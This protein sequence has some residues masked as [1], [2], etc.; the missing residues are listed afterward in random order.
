VGGT[1]RDG[2]QAQRGGQG[3]GRRARATHRR[4]PPHAP[5][6]AR[7]AR[8][9]RGAGRADARRAPTASSG[10]LGWGGPGG[11][12]EH[13]GAG[14]DGGWSE[15]VEP[16]GGAACRQGL[17]PARRAGRSRPPPGRRGS[18]PTSDGRP[19]PRGSP[20]VRARGVHQAG[21]SGLEPSVEADVPTPSSGV[22]PRRR[23]PHAVPVG[24]APL[25]S[26]GDVRAVASAGCGAPR[27]HELWRRFVARR[28]G[29]RRG[30]T[31]RRQWG[32]AGVGA[33]GA[34]GPPTRGSS[35]GGVRSPLVATI[36]GAG[37][38]MSGAQPDSARGPLTRHAADM[39]RVRR[40]RSAAEHAR[41]AV[42]PS[43]PTL[44]LTGPPPKTGSV[45]GTRAG[46]EGLGGHVHPGSARQSGTLIPR[47][48]P[49]PQAMQA[50]RRHRREPP[51][52]RGVRPTLAA[53]GA[54]RHR[55]RRGWRHEC[56]V[57]PSTKTGPA[58]ERSVR[59]RV[60]PWLRARVPRGPPPEPRPALERPSGRASCAARG[61]GGPQP[62]THLDDGGRQAGGGR[63][64]RPG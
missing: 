52:R 39:G 62:G 64:A 63:T 5:A 42:R 8:R 37:G 43:V 16:P 57:G 30:W 11:K 9:P 15:D 28:R 4:G 10:L 54:T 34:G 3:R 44:H 59:P 50:I 13:L 51:A 55:S 56:G 14:G 17:A 2:H 49:G 26:Q 12:S 24:P 33:E 20:T 41:Q 25:G 31:R 45:D 58:L 29:D 18:R 32:P 7:S 1:E 53:M 35:P 47:L 38:Q 61:R 48:W 6:S 19:T 46:G 27:D 60:G 36:D 23:A 22:G 21:P 40:T